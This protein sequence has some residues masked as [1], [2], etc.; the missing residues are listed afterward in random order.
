LLL[1]EFLYRRFVCL[2]R[3]IRQL[4]ES[5]SKARMAAITTPSVLFEGPSQSSYLICD[6]QQITGLPQQISQEVGFSSFSASELTG[7]IDEL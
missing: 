7:G 2:I 5:R 3:A 6:S 1:F 4:M